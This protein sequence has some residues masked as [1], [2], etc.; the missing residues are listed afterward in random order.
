[1]PRI[2]IHIKNK[3]VTRNKYKA[4]TKTQLHEYLP[5]ALREISREPD[6]LHIEIRTISDP[7]LLAY[8][9][10]VYYLKKIFIGNQPI[11]YYIKF[12]QPKNTIRISYNESLIDKP[13]YL[14]TQS[15]YYLYSSRIDKEGK[16]HRSPLFNHGSKTALEYYFKQFWITLPDNNF[17]NLE[18][19]LKG[20][21]L[22][23]NSTTDSPVLIELSKKIST[24]LNIPSERIYIY[25]SSFNLHIKIH[26][27]STL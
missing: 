1:M 17:L 15:T 26:K 22:L 21:S 13:E 27:V 2:N 9:H 11:K 5:K 12:N 23:K 19:K 10:T 18:V 20:S 3:G 8:T 6:K 16:S 4:Y 25:T 7:Y 14:E 24:F